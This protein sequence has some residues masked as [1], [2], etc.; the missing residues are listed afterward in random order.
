MFIGLDLSL[1]GTG[2]VALD[3]NAVITTRARFSVPQKGVERLYH[4]EN[5]FLD[6]LDIYETISLCCIES[7][8]FGISEG[9]LFNL[10]TWAGIVELNLFK[11]GIPY[12]KASPTQVKK[13]CTGSGKGDKNLILLKTYQ[14]FG[15]EFDSDDICDAYLLA[16]IARSYYY[17]HQHPELGKKLELKKYHL[18]VLQKI[19]DTEK[20]KSESLLK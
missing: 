5:K 2:V 13:Y 19:N 6:F 15:E 14:N 11:K 20:E 3:G 1:G 12:I 7:P 9:H 17:S 8:A 18:Q 16:M 4:L 10:G